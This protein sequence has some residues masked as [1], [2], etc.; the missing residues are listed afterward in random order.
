MEGGGRK[1][2]LKWD[3]KTWVFRRLLSPRAPVILTTF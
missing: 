2:V 3:G 1:Q